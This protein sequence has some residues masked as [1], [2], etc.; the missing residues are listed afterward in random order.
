LTSVKPIRRNHFLNHGGNEWEDSSQRC[1]IH[2][3]G[4]RKKIWESKDH[5][6]LVV[7]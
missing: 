3:L 6:L 5:H 7:R 1:I 4:I 2:P